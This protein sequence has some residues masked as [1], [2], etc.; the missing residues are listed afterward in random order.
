MGGET[1]LDAEVVV[2][3]RSVTWLIHMSNM[4]H[5]QSVRDVPVP[6]GFDLSQ[7]LSSCSVIPAKRL[8]VSTMTSYMTSSSLM[9]VA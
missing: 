4:D 8:W 9:N 6:I 7:L 1:M 2:S 3:P 5:Q